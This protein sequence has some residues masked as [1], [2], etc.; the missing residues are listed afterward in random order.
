MG[1]D[2]LVR[3]R[4]LA[5]LPLGGF[6][7]RPIFYVGV[8]CHGAATLD[9]GDELGVIMTAIDH[10]PRRP[11]LYLLIVTSLALVACPTLRADDNPW[12]G[13]VDALVKPLIEK[14]KAVGIVVGIVSPDGKR[15]FFCYGA[16]KEGGPEPTPDTLFEIG[17]VSKPITALLLALMVEDGTARLDDPVQKY[18]PKEI[19]V[20]RR[21]KQEITLLELVTHVWVAEKSSQSTT[22]RE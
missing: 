15:Q 10:K 18:L 8:D 17:S 21:G 20:P 7:S 2:H 4:H 5:A 16:M 22:A 6:F 14:K 11:F 3:G 12:K 1:H 19:V 9:Y 13:Q